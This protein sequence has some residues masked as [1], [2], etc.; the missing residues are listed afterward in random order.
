MGFNSAF[1]GL[2]II[3]VNS[4]VHKFSTSQGAT[5]KFQAPVA[6]FTFRIHKQWASQYKMLSN[7]RP[8]TRNLYTSRLTDFC[9][10]LIPN[11]C[12]RTLLNP[13]YTRSTPAASEKRECR[14]KFFE[15]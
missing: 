13:L 4:G 12:Y 11:V 9:D 8:G 2:N 6:S 3:P 1:K 7:G 15:G 5:S 14:N 10:G